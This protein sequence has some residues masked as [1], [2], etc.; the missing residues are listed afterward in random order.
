MSL[1][2]L[3]IGLN[4]VYDED[5]EIIRQKIAISEFPDLQILNLKEIF[6]R[7]GDKANNT[8]MLIEAIAKHCSKIEELT[9]Y[10]GP[11]DFI[12]VKSL[13]LNCRNLSSI[14][15]NSLDSSLNMNGD[16]LLDIF[17]NFS[18][19]SLVKI[20]L[21][22]KWKAFE[23]IFESYR[24]RTLNFFGIV[25]FDKNNNITVAQRVLVCQNICEEMIM[26]SNCGIEI[27]SE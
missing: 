11:K 5:K 21:S 25:D 16:E 9:T 27:H 10:L 2:N 22:G 1:I 23:R 15:L 18:P 26:D 13:L 14:V 3:K 8:G 6:Q 4:N 19:E 12:H 20:S 7:I 24:N 17:S